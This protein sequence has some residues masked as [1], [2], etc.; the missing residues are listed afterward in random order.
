MGSTAIRRVVES[1]VDIIEH[2]QYLTPEL[3]REMARRGVAYTP[4]LSSYDTQTMHP[5]F[6][7]G[8]AWKTAHDEL[9]AGHA[10]AIAAALDAG[11]RI[12]NG[13]DSVGCY[14]EEVELLREAGMSAVDS[15]LACTRYPAEALAMA[16]D[17]GT[18]E[19]GKRADIVILEEDPLADPYALEAVA[20]VLKG[21]RAYSPSELTYFERVTR[22]EWNMVELA[23]HPAPA[24][25]REAVAAG[26]A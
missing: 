7:R 3:A 4:T 24:H 19:E 23:R 22:P 6:V 15:L 1:G 9:L 8:Q 14:A 26:V 18:V 16:A 2:G 17:V 21:G 12:L 20:L 13:T 5:R 10:G 25:E 11:V